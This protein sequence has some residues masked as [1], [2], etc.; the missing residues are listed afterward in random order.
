MSNVR[1][2]LRLTAQDAAAWLANHPTALVLDARE[3]RHHVQ[4]NLKG[5]LRLDGRNHE[6]LLMREEKERPVFIYCYH[7]NASQTYAE[8]FTDFG[9]EQVCDLIGGWEAWQ[10]VGG[11]GQVVPTPAAAST[12][13]AAPGG[14]PVPEMLQRWLSEHGLSDPHT[15]GDHGNTPLM[16]AA[17]RGETAIVE[18]LLAQGVSLTAVN[19]DGNNALWLGCVS[20]DPALVIMLARAGVPIDHINLTGA[21]CLM[22]ASSSSKPDIVRVLLALGA[23]PLIQTQDDYTA[24]DMAASLECLQLLRAATKGT[25]QAAA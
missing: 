2:F 3:E 1:R 4:G 5:S 24:M 22:Y 12:P 20:N 14:A 15:P 18:A 16:Q 25:T 9:F 7:G 6:R 19:G 10:Q 23:D 11:Q 8:M 17:W 13:G 21:T